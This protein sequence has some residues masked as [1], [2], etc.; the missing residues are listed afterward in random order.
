[1]TIEHGLIKV[2][3]IQTETIPS[4]ARLFIDIN[5]TMHS[6]KHIRYFSRAGF[7]LTINTPDGNKRVSATPEDMLVVSYANLDGEH[8]A[9]VYAKSRN[10]S[11]PLRTFERDM[12][13]AIEGCAGLVG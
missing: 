6:V 2:K 9:A 3:L 8:A 12:H 11:L 1:M 7:R 4:G 10:A 13:V 5:G